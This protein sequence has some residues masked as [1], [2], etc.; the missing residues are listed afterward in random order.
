MLLLF[1][2]LPAELLITSYVCLIICGVMA[3]PPINFGLWENFLF[4]LKNFPLKNAKFWAQNPFW[5]TLW[6]KLKFWAPITLSEICSCL[7]ENCNFLSHLLFNPQHRCWLCEMFAATLQAETQ[8]W[9]EN[10]KSEVEKRDADVRQLQ[11]S[12][13]EAEG[14]LVSTSV[15]FLL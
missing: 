14:L 1:T 5:G 15:S 8:K 4:L 6:A 2:S 7:S 11:R 12:L 3:M 9:F 10:L 13:K